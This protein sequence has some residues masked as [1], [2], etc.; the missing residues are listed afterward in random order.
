M[1][2]VSMLAKHWFFRGDTDFNRSASLQFF[3]AFIGLFTG[4]F[5]VLDY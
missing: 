5:A 4:Y 1:L 2:N 3:T